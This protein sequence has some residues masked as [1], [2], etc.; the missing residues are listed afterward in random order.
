MYNYRYFWLKNFVQVVIELIICGRKL[1]IANCM[2]KNE[3][4]M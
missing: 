2:F 4:A 1:N 3:S